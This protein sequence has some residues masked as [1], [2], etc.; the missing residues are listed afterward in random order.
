[1]SFFPT[2]LAGPITRVSV[3]LE[4]METRRPLTPEDGGRALFLFGTGLAKKFLIADYLAG[5][6]IDRVFD[7]P[8]LY[9]GAEVLLSA[10]G[11][12]VQ[13]YYD[14]LGYTDIA[15]GSAMLVGIRLPANFKQPYAAAH[16]VDF[17]RRWARPPAP[18]LRVVT[19][20]FS[21][22]RGCCIICRTA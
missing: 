1:M 18:M 8:N 9:S 13:L 17:W 5:Q 6:L 11:Y 20:W 15:M 10:Y 19:G 12:A 14:F 2:I 4:Q 3:L 16:I 22:W 21:Q 7:F